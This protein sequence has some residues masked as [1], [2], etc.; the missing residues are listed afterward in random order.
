MRNALGGP[1]LIRASVGLAAKRAGAER[2]TGYDPD[3]GALATAAERGAV[4][5]P[6]ASLAEA[7]E[8]VELIVV[9]A[10]VAQLAGQVAAVLAAA[11][12]TATVTDVGSTKAAVCAAAAGSPR[13]IGG[14]PVCGSEARGPQHAREIGRASGRGRV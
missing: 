7:L 5:Q 4:D 1:G 3:A 6:A 9:A 2:V 13:F 10:P 11:P 12:D 8:A 14:H